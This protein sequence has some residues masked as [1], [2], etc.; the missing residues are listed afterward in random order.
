MYSADF[1]G[2]SLKHKH[3]VSV[4]LEDAAL[5]PDNCFTHVFAN[6][7]SHGHGPYDRKNRGWMNYHWR[8][9]RAT[10][11]SARVVVSDWASDSEP[12][13]PVGQE[14]MYNFVQVQPYEK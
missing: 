13:G 10:G 11:V 9:F 2:L 12:G 1:N 7:Y 6:C 8:V 4:K 3:A 5:A 14:L